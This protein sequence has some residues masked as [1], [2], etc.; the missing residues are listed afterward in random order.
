MPAMSD[1]FKGETILRER[2]LLAY[3]FED[4]GFVRIIIGGGADV[5]LALDQ[6]NL[7][8]KMKCNEIFVLEKRV[9]V[10]GW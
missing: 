8:V 2:T 10:E 9:K 6:I 5:K 1:E 7:L 3:T 4:G